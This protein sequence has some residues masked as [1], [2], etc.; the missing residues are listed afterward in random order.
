MRVGGESRN[1]K[2]ALNS[3]G[4]EP[5]K[6]QKVRFQ[7]PPHPLYITRTS[8]TFPFVGPCLCASC[9]DSISRCQSEVVNFDPRCSSLTRVSIIM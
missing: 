5:W 8:Y 9:V 7:R 3:V 4:A 2:M 6:G 1:C